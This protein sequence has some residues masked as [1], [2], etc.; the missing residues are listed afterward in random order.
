V[1]SPHPFEFLRI[2]FAVLVALS[3][4]QLHFELQP[5]HYLIRL[6]HILAAA[7]FFGGIAALDL[8][9][10][11]WAREVK[12]RSLGTMIL[13]WL[14]ALFAVAVA[15]GVTLFLYDPVGV[16]S[17]GY[18]TPKLI[19][20]GL[21]LANALAFHRY[22]YLAA[23]TAEGHVPLSGR[24]A[25]GVSLALWIGVMVCASMNVEGVPKVMLR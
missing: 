6:A 17:H 13:P 5:W 9:L 10:L 4:R 3:N 7:G 21:G 14:A 12:L 15:S 8:R 16:G 25:G 22:G 20:M 24:I 23:V 11:G 19:L 1:P 18:F 2:P